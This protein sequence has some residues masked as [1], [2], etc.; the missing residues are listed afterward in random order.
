[1]ASW[2]KE[3]LLCID[4][5]ILQVVDQAITWLPLDKTKGKASE[6]KYVVA[7]Y[8]MNPVRLVRTLRAAPIRIAD[9]MQRGPPVVQIIDAFDN[10]FA[11]L[12]VLSEEGHKVE[13]T[14]R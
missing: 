11:I 1:M 9:R 12:S 8:F 4:R 14:F 3:K 5:Q 2:A 6:S 7:T 10:W 13:P